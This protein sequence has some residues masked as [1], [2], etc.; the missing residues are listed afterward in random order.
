MI[1]Y[2]IY[3]YIYIY[4]IG[5]G[6]FVKQLSSRWFA[7]GHDDDDDDVYDHRLRYI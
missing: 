4:I 5:G 1:Y 6:C 7:D 3:I 2:N